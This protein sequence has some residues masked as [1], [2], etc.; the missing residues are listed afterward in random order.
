M[1]LATPKETDPQTRIDYW[2]MLVD[3]SLKGLE[4][5]GYQRT[6]DARIKSDIHALEQ[7][8]QKRH[9]LMTELIQKP[10]E[11][12]DQIHHEFDLLGDPHKKGMARLLSKAK[13]VSTQASTGTDVPTSQD[14]DHILRQVA[15]NTYLVNEAFDIRRITAMDQLKMLERRLAVLRDGRLISVPDLT[16]V[17]DS[18]YVF[19]GVSVPYVLR[20]S[21]NE[22]KI[23][24]MAYVDDAMHGEAVN[25][26]TEWL[27]INIV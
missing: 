27:A 14:Q 6:P 12:I 23:V 25:D 2:N 5:L 8:M 10:Q 15:L 17:G 16:R 7:A 3:M 24:G 11:W 20:G 4:I 9:L 1:E 18:V 22:F 21:G 19:R 13:A 26:S